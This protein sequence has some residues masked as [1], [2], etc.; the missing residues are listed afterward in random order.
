MV[1]NF[2]ARG[3]ENFAK[4]AVSLWLRACD[5]YQPVTPSRS[6]AF[7]HD[8]YIDLCRVQWIYLTHEFYMKYQGFELAVLCDVIQLVSWLDH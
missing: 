8:T 4:S 6:N 2:S 1:D 5:Q 3:R 7:N